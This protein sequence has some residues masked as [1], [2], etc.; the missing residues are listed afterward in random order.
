MSKPCSRQDT[1]ASL[2]CRVATPASHPVPATRNAKQSHDK[3]LPIFI[4]FTPD[5]SDISY[6]SPE[7]I[8][9]RIE[10]GDALPTGTIA[11]P[12]ARFVAPSRHRGRILGAVARPDLG[13][14]LEPWPAGFGLRQALGPTRGSRLCRGAGLF[15][16]RRPRSDTAGAAGRSAACGAVR[17]SQH[18][19]EV[20]SPR[21]RRG[22]L[23]PRE[24]RSDAGALS[25]PV[26]HCRACHT[27][28]Q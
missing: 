23:L 10:H 22:D 4:G 12:P 5:S 8:A 17:R 2:S 6:L 7:M 20:Q 25:D 11:G 27:A 28:S 18:E 14:G 26:A 13:P 24:R 1:S 15:L 3:H 16:W 9:C 19:T 21:A